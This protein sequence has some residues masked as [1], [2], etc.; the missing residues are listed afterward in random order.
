MIL[1]NIELP[2]LIVYILMGI[3]FIIMIW[4]LKN[5]NTK[6]SARLFIFLGV[7]L[8]IG[9][10][11]GRMCISPSK[12]DNARFSRNTRIFQDAKVEK[13]AEYITE[14]FKENGATVAFLIDD[15]SNSDPESENFVMLESLQKRLNEKGAVWTEVL[16]V[17]EKSVD[18]KGVE[19][20]D[21]PMDAAIMNKKLN[22]VYDKVD[23]VVNFA[24]LPR[25]IS[26]LKK[27]TFLTKK[28][29]ATGKNNMLL[30]SCTGLPFVEQDMFK[31]GRVCAIIDSSSEEGSSFNI[32]KDSVSRNLS[33]VFDTFFTLI[34]PQ[35]LSD[36]ISD[37]PNYFV[38][39]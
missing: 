31:S 29:T 2:L 6:P 38:S 39:K 16:V 32:R 4:G 8:V 23:I 15:E 10:V 12:T 28:N 35:T 37:N 14:R 18:K 19:K 25:S 20:R 5:Q 9:G 27:I 33:E 11:V 30:M 7:A 1:A 24:G 34:T 22:Q 17:G 21:D 26:E 3:G 13:A 36:F